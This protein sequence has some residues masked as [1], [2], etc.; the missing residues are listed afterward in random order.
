MSFRV[1]T[2]RVQYGLRYASLPGD[3]LMKLLSHRYPRARM[4]TLILANESYRA[5][6][7]ASNLDVSTKYRVRDWLWSRLEAQFLE[8]R[9]I[10]LEDPNT[11]NRHPV[12]R[13]LMVCRPKCELDPILYLPATRVDRS[14]L[15]RW[16]LNF[17]PGEPRECPCSGE[18]QTRSHFDYCAAI[19][20]DLFNSFPQVTIYGLC[21]IDA[22]L[23]ALPTSASASIPDY[24]S[25]LLYCSLVH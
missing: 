19:P 9:T 20:P 17:L 2:C 1:Q 7:S 21:R 22:A 15:V 23:N 16:R 14:R 6:V 18:L 11:H 8:E 24:W 5:V 25:G 4:H 3:C 12:G 10:A 13:L